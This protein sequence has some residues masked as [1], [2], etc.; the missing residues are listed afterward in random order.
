MMMT[1]EQSRSLDE[2]LSQRH[3][4]F[5]AKP[6]KVL[7][8]A[9]ELANYVVKYDFRNGAGRRTQSLRDVRASA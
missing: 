5:A 7:V 1:P 8:D 4:R 6:D 9:R 2:Y 3:E